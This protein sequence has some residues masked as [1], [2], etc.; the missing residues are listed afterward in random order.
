[1]SR[2]MSSHRSTRYAL[3]LAGAAGAV[4]FAGGAAVADGAASPSPV[5]KSPAA[6]SPVPSV[7]AS[8]TSAP[9]AK[10]PAPASAVPADRTGTPQPP[11]GGAQTGE[12]EPG[13]SRTA[14]LLG[15]GIALTGAAGLGIALRRRRADARG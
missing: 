6:A 5:V 2:A 7:P 12:A 9:A 11:R 15:S 14:V 13:G 1:M 8:R 4:L 3:V 10:D